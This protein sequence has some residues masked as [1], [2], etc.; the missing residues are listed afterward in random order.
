MF[1]MFA[2][3]VP[4]EAAKSEMNL[5]SSSFIGSGKKL[6]QSILQLIELNYLFYF[7]Y[8]FTLDRY[9]HQ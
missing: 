4:V 9:R 1:L 2:A 5:L 6:I 7:K 3:I 8:K